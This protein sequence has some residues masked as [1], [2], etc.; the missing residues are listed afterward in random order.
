MMNN[1]ELKILGKLM[2]NPIEA[3]SINQ[4][5][6]EIKLAYPYVYAS[7]TKL[8]REK[9]ISV[10]KSGKSNLCQLKFD[11][12]EKLALASME[13]RDEFLSKHLP[14]NNLTKQLKEALAEELYILLLFGSYAKGKATKQSDLD[15]FFVVNDEKAIEPFRKKVSLVISKLNYKVEFGISTLAW[16]YEMLSDK[17]TV[18]SEIFKTNVIL[19]NAETYFHLVKKYDQR[20]GY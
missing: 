4:L 2:R 15:L 1:C 8:E 10:K 17:T 20:K 6:K 18:G 19:H 13:M 5:A 16:F 7:I 3:Y 12:P 9:L 11:H 14:L